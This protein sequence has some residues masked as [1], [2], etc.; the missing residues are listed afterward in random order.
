MAIVV[1]G[2]A[3]GCASTSLPPRISSDQRALL[4]RT[5]IDA[6]V[7]VEDYAYPVYSDDLTKALESTHLFIRVDHLANFTNPPDF[8]VR[9]ED[10]IYGSAT[11]PVL[12]G[13][14]LGLIPT[15]VQETHGYSFSLSRPG[16][17]K[18]RVLIRFAYTGPTT[19]GWWAV[20]LNVLP[21][22]TMGDVDS[23]PRFIES[24][25]WEIVTNR[26]AILSLKT[27]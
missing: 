4:H 19:L 18:P 9:V 22:R 23:H 12:T 20:L 17:A 21:S 6:T 13:L 15:T 27:K 5:R 3:G 16:V 11:V 24:F 10:R 8:V 26:E 1:V 7:G 2:L 25:A 14:S